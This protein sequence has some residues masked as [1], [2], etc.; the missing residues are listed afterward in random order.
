M[1]GHLFVLRGDLTKLHCSAVLIPCDSEWRVV[2]DHWGRFLPEGCL[3]RADGWGW[4]PFMR[5][6][7]GRFTDVVTTGDKRVRLVVT[8]DDDRTDDSPRQ[9]A[10]WV[11][12]GVV[13]V[14]ADWSERGLPKPTGRIKPLIGL[15]LVGTGAGGFQR[16]RGVL[17]HALVP[18]LRKAACEHGVDIALVL[19][20]DRDHAAVQAVR[21]STD[22]DEFSRERPGHSVQL[23]IA[24]E[25]GRKA[26]RKEL[27]LFLGSG[28]SVPLGV[29]DWKTLLE[30]MDPEAKEGFGAKEPRD[31]ASDIEGRIG[32]PELEQR[33]VKEVG[34]SG[35]APTHMLLAALSVDQSVTTNYDTAY[36]RA[37]DTTLGEDKFRVLT[38]QLALQPNPWL[39]KY[40]GCINQPNTIVIT[41][42]D[43]RRLQNEHGALQSIVESLMLT[44]HL[45]FVG[46]SMADADF[47]DAATRVDA[48]RALAGK[49]DPRYVATVLALHPQAVMARAGFKVVSML[50]DPDEQSAARILEIFLDRVSWAATTEGPAAST[51]LLHPD[52]EDLF[53]DEESTVILRKQLEKLVNDVGARSPVWGNRGWKQVAALLSQL[54][55][56]RF[57]DKSH[58]SH[59]RPSESRLMRD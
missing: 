42:E 53:A 2:E 36:D 40:H 35:V 48:V 23:G 7:E 45:M 32:R 26:A 24:D 52:Y 8:A 25:L 19:I 6:G 18:A 39:L 38:G 1:G 13:E 43:Y 33:V 34:L 10:S 27:S 58:L 11:A 21:K 47:L 56:R 37:L 22:W 16:A 14:I 9:T 54:G 29:P 59:C 46:F 15:P 41:R 3:G 20:D 51:Y 30:R 55:D 5:G 4:A 50:E 17:I 28:V 44:S 57:G 12:D 49:Q 31:I